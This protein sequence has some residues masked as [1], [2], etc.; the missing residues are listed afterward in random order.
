[1]R[2]IATATLELYPS[3]YAL[4]IPLIKANGNVNMVI[5][6]LVTVFMSLWINRKIKANVTGMMMFNR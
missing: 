3:Q 6:D 5:N 1:M 4:E 2:P